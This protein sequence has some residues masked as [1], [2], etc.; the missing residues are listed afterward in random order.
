MAIFCLIPS[1]QHSGK[2][3]TMEIKKKDKGMVRGRDEQAEHRGFLG[4]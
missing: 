4:Q 1:T 3:K 2:G